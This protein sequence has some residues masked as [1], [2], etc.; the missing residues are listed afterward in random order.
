MRI[1]ISVILSIFLLASC[2]L[3]EETPGDCPAAISG[4]DI[5]LSFRM[6]AAGLDTHTRA[7][8]LDHEEVESEYRQ[9]EDGVDMNDV[10]MFIFAK[11]AGSA[12]E[13]KLLLKVIDI[14][15]TFASDEMEIYGGPGYY[16]VNINLTKNQL[17]NIL[18]Q[19][20][21]ADGTELV[22]FRILL[23]A[24][25]STSGTTGLSMAKWNQITGTTYAQVIEQLNVWV[26]TME[27]FYNEN[28]GD[29]VTQL[30]QNQRKNMPMFGT[31]LF[32][33]SQGDLYNSRPESPVPLGDMNMLRSLAKV[34]VVDNIQNKGADGYPKIIG[35]SI[36]SSQSYIHTMP[37]DALNYINGNQVHTPYIANPEYE[38]GE[39]NPFTY[40]LGILPAAWSNLPS[41]QYKGDIRVGYIPEQSIKQV[42]NDVSQ[43]MPIFQVTVALSKNADGT[44]ET[45]IY[46]IPMTGYKD[47]VFSFGDYIL[48]NHIYTLSVN[49]ISMDTEAD[50]TVNVADWIPKTFTLDYSETLTVS[51]KLQWTP[52]SYFSKND[53]T[54]I[55]I[56]K[57]WVTG[58]NGVPTWIPITA[59]F[60]IQSPLGATWIASLIP[61]EGSTNAFGFLVNGE[62][63]T[64]ASGTI[65]SPYK[66]NL[67]IVSMNDSPTT[68]NSAKLQVVVTLANGTVLEAN[69]TPDGST[70]DNYTILQNPVNFNN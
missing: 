59:S 36:V 11:L 52:N 46:H 18:G 47:Q 19:E 23:V 26:Y 49:E 51:Q 66:Y 38:I 54:G 35:A 53:N 28:G 67:S 48:R 44:E 30:Y 41:S 69:L 65:V 17:T 32:Y 39:S 56:T 7:D 21:T 13:E 40:K 15:A 37:Y 4:E 68:R 2:S 50:I 33:A 29:D 31:N 8:Y 3:V 42:N 58:D 64:T 12:E 57:P 16:T 61:L 60:G 6:L 1:Y 9:F 43:G 10:G 34:R 45:K 63:K 20:I 5:S 25:S 62:L 70:Y 22:Q 24:N 14:S 27:Y 55:V